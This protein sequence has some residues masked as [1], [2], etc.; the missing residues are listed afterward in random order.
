MMIG[1]LHMLSLHWYVD[2]R[3]KPAYILW[4]IS[5]MYMYITN[6]WEARL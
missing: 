1:S 2:L 5:Y 4:T 3:V 6:L